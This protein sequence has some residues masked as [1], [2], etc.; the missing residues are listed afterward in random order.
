MVRR[1]ALALCLLLFFFY[2]LPRPRRHDVYRVFAT[3]PYFPPPPPPSRTIYL[4]LS[5]SAPSRPARSSQRVSAGS[6]YPGPHEF[7]W[8]FPKPWVGPAFPTLLERFV[9]VTES[10]LG[11]ENARDGGSSATVIFTTD[12]QWSRELF[13]LF[14]TR[15]ESADGFSG[16]ISKI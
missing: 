8:L 7:T 4:S 14:P 13:W 15:V 12:P 5:L 2:F 6:P 9:S 10:F 16:N 3:S 11:E 1:R